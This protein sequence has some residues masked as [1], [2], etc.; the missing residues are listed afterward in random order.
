MLIARRTL[1]ELLA[2]LFAAQALWAGAVEGHFERVAENVYAHVGDIGARSVANEGL[3]A[4]LGLVVTQG[5][6]C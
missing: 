3:N 1:A 4:N 2:A 5:V 6:R